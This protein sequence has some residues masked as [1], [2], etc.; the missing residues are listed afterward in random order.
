MSRLNSERLSMHKLT[1]LIFTRRILFNAT[2]VSLVVGTL[3]N[4]INQWE[5]ILATQ[6]IMFGHLLMSYLVP[7]CASAYIGAK[8]LSLQTHAN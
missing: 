2:K 5:Y 8:A 7:F 4:M 6:E 1:R 3:L